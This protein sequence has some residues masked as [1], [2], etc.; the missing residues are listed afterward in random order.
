[1]KKPV[2]WTLPTR[3]TV[4]PPASP[5]RN[6][7]LPANASESPAP[8]GSESRKHRSGKTPGPARRAGGGMTVTPAVM[9]SPTKT[10][11]SVVLLTLLGHRESCA[12]LQR[13]GLVA[14]CDCPTRPLDDPAVTVGVVVHF[15]RI[16]LAQR[17]PLPDVIIEL[18]ARGVEDGDPACIVVAEWL[19]ACGLVRLRPLSRARRRCS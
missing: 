10:S 9:M 2:P 8:W 12:Q 1:M 17:C 15:A 11:A 14:S 16:S 13:A 4:E 3:L 18:L 5:I 7:A 19:D 6:R